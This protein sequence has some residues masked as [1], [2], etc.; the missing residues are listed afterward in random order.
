MQVQAG[1]GGA[2][3]VSRSP[4]IIGFMEKGATGRL[5]I[6]DREAASILAAKALV[7]IRHLAGR[8]RRLPEEHPHADALSEIRF[9]AD[10]C[11]NLPGVASLPRQRHRPW[12][13]GN[14][15]WRSAP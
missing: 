1:A 3:V 4:A 5:E 14:G 6:D 2:V 12:T 15:L 9:L 10:L 13:A 8:A 7:E 11:H